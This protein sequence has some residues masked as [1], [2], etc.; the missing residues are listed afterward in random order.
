MSKYEHIIIPQGIKE[1]IGYSSIVSGGG[2]SFIPERNRQIH[3]QYL[4]KRF[5]TIKAENTK[6]KQQMTAL[7]LPARRGTYLEFSSALGYDL[8]SKSLE[9]Q[10]K[11]IRLLNIR[12]VTTEDD[13]KQTLATIYIPHGEEKVLLGKLHKYATEESN[14]KPKNDILFRSIEDVKLALL[15]ALWT[16]NQE[17]FP[18][19][20]DDWYEVWIRISGI[21]KATIDQQCNRFKT[22]LQSLRIP[23]KKD[24]ILTFPERAVFLVCANKTS[25]ANLLACSDQL[26]ELRMGRALTGFLFNENRSE[27]QEWVDDLLSRLEINNDTDSVVCVLDSGVN[28]GHPLLEPI[29]PEK[30]CG[31][32]VG[33]GIADGNGHGTRMCGTVIYGDMSSYLANNQKIQIDNQIGSVKLLPHSRSNPKE[34]WG[35]LT[36]QAVATSEIIFPRKTVCYCMAITAE[37]SEQGK[38]TSWSGAV[39]SIAYNN[40]NIGRLF[41][42]SAGN[43]RDINFLDKDIIN[44][45]PNNHSLRKIQN[46]AQAWNALTIGAFT[47]IVAPNSQELR[48]YERVAPIGGIS[49]FSRTSLLWDKT[50]LIKPEVM[51]EGGNLYKTKD[52][53]LPFSTHQDL[54]LMTTSENYQKRGYFETINATS[55]ATA[56]A[57]NFAGRL[58][59]K[60]PHLWAESIRGLIVHSAKWTSAMEEQFPVRKG[61]RADMIQRLRHCG[62]GVPSEERAFYSTENGL[63]YIAQEEIQP[64][65]KQGDNAPKMNKMH[66]FELPWPREILEQ[67]AETNVTMRVTLSYFIEPAPGEIGWKDK[68]RYAS[69]GLRFDVNTEAEDQRAFQLRINGAIEAEENEERSKNDSKR[70]LIGADNRNRGSIHSDELNLTAAQ[71]ATCNLI[72]VYPIGGWWKTR[73]NLDKFNEKLRY[74]LIVSLDTPAEN[75][76]LYNA[77][78]TKIETMIKT[79][80]E[81]K[82]PTNN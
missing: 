12:Q 31:S 24:S 79:P 51:F 74:S 76:D 58:Q 33:E 81:V 41:I 48:G 6:V 1:A 45:Y 25:L 55:A 82:I 29:I 9:N 50:S 19:E 75:I 34:I 77:V 35:F 18:T 72:A 64:F 61:N 65:K 26:A 73:T 10:K 16:D 38:P 20:K 56:L 52:S 43:I 23:Y 78:K 59:V 71:L 8:V 57:S 14:G 2:R 49:P 22:S 7:S 27:Q 62:Y 21:E 70:W 40:G 39:D 15:E 32:V 30:N 11:G 37:D 42:V 46:P 13:Q 36:E 28:N 66:F 54:E 3:A 80:I 4:R 47:N 44:A 5:D 53:L 67:L 63:T 68:Y 17:D 69:C 60:Y